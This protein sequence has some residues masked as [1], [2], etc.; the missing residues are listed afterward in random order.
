MV[1]TIR[2]PAEIKKLRLSELYGALAPT[3]DFP[4]TEAVREEV[5]RALGRELEKRT[6]GE[7]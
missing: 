5:E 4:G 1:A 2:I 6:K 3:R 7:P